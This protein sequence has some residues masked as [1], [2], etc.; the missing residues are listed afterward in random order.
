MPSRFGQFITS[1]L[2]VHRPDGS[3]NV[4]LFS[5]PR[6]GSTWLME[7]IWSQPGFKACNEPLNI[8]VPEVRAHLGIDS[9]ERLYQIDEIEK[10]EK[11]LS[12]WISGHFK[13]K[14]RRPFSRNYRPIT[15]RI[16]FKIIH[17]CQDN[18]NSLKEKLNG[19][20]IFLL[21]HPLAVSISRKE[22]PC[23]NAFLNSDYARHFTASQRTFAH[24]IVHTGSRLEQGVLT[25][26]LENAVPMKEQTDDWL[27]VTYEQT[28]LEPEVV[29]HHMADRLLLPK[30]LEMNRKI[31]VPSQSTTKSTEGTQDLLRNADSA[32]TKR[33]LLGK[34]RQQITSNDACK[35]MDILQR[36]ELDS[37]YSWDSDVPDPNLWLRMSSTTVDGRGDAGKSIPIAD[38]R[39]T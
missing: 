18:I 19:R 39:D 5:S 26:C 31:A 30:P 8:R 25:W 32:S 10:I 29:I 14:N 36:F 35:A 22:L 27:V 38:V 21:R 17:G 11:Y 20:I 16:V 28:V 12:G 37:I 7:L 33:A 3:P 13:F 6:S 24:E 15:R 34:W 1:V 9:W 2:P 4:F 23:L